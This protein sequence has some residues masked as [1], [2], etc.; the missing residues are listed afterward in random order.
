MIREAVERTTILKKL[1]S[2]VLA[3]VLAVSASALARDPDS[4]PPALR[5]RIF[6]ARD[7]SAWKFDVENTS[8]GAVSIIDDVR[9]LRL[10]ITEPGQAKA[11][12]CG[13]PASMVPRN[14]TGSPSKR[15]ASRDH[16]VHSFDPRFYCF[17]ERKS[18][19]LT[20]GARIVP[21]YGWPSTERSGRK[22]RRHAPAAPFVAR[23]ADA[24]RV[25]P[26]AD[27][28]GDAF[29]LDADSAL[30]APTH[31][32]AKSA[33][34][35]ELR[36]E[37]ARGSDADTARSA[38]ATVRLKNTTG[39]AVV[40]YFRRP[41]LTFEV[42]G[43]KGTVECKPEEEVLHPARRS[44]THLGP[45]AST[46]LVTRLI[47]FCPLGTFASRG[48]YLVNAEFEADETGEDFGFHAFTGRLRADEPAPVRI[49][50]TIQLFPSYPIASA[51]PNQ[52]KLPVPGGAP[53]RTAAPPALTTTN[54]A[55]PAGRGR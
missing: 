23:G 8:P 10:E 7:P 49:R 17:G 24:D 39:H 29:V 14:A 37:M 50:R 41:L 1:M 35:P 9:L 42:Q 53:V 20:A 55:P 3:T 28:V 6:T 13:L 4:E 19:L 47:E 45:E 46:S 2:S 12:F 18:R 25:R 44:F 34:S 27:V 22:R 11:A 15:L 21:H 54:R 33:T 5:L 26:I 38:T 36:L 31:E 43:P 40:A 52:A 30:P 48:F 16:V 32:V 51:F